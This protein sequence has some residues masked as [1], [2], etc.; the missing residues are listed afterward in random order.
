MNIGEAFD[1]LIQGLLSALPQSP[2]REFLAEFQNLPGLGTLN[3]FFPVGG[4][5]RVMAAWLVAVALFLIYSVAMRW[6]KLIGD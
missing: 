4:V 3:W 1:G 6:V 2:F 5:L